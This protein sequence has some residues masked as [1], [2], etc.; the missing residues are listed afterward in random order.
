MREMSWWYASIIPVL[1]TEAGGPNLKSGW[2]TVKPCLKKNN[3]T[4]AG[5]PSE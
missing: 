5:T 2:F 4:G 1:G 3:T